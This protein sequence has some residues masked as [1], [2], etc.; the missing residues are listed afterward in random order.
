MKSENGDDSDDFEPDVAL[1]DGGGARDGA[2]G[3][4]SDPPPDEPGPPVGQKPPSDAGPILTPRNDAARPPAPEAG[5]PPVGEGPGEDGG[6]EPVVDASVPKSDAGPAK[7]ASQPPPPPPPPVD[8]SSPDAS[9]PDA[10]G[11]VEAGMPGRRCP[12]GTYAGSFS[13]EISALL[14]LV[15]IDI[16]GTI[17]IDI[18][19]PEPNGQLLPIRNG[20]LMGKDQDDNPINAVITGTLNCGT[21]RLDN[22]RISGGTYTRRDPLWGGPPTTVRFTGSATATFNLDPP[23]ATGRWEVENENGLRGGSGVWSATLR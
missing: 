2:R 10:S 5:T 15:R 7:D 9:A 6:A 23:S 19:E 22:G 3:P 8:A 12:P 11:P 13:G 4:D 18:G 14:G 1:I 16:T 17:S 20:K 21:L